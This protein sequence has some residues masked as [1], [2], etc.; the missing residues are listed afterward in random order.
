LDEIKG[1]EVTVKGDKPEK[2]AERA[3]FWFATI[4]NSADI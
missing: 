3:R 4:G 2:L 1:N